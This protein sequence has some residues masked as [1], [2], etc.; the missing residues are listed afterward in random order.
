MGKT[1]NLPGDLSVNRETRRTF[2]HRQIRKGC[3]IRHSST[4]QNQCQLDPVNGMKPSEAILL[5]Q[6]E[7]LA[8]ADRHHARNVRVF[9]SVVRGEDT[10]QS[11]LDLLVEFEKTPTLFDLSGFQSDLEEILDV[12]VE[13]LSEDDVPGLRD[14]IREE[15]VS[16]AVPLETFQRLHLVLAGK[17]LDDM[18]KEEK[19]RR[20]SDYLKDILDCADKIQQFTEKMDWN[21]FEKNPMCQ[22]AVE[23]ELITIGEASKK[24]LDDHGDFVRLHPEL[25]FKKAYDLRVKLTHG[26][27]SINARTVWGTIQDNLPD[28]A[29]KIREILPELLKEREIGRKK[30]NDSGIGY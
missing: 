19:K 25:P 17:D 18:R 28:F 30:R 27:T 7:I 11:D 9:G 29:R 5:H 22:S 14:H 20:I 4:R 15:I 24:I 8:V 12:P 6:N 16:E 1:E 10:D 3:G 2:D 23:R 21:G 26:Y 13:I